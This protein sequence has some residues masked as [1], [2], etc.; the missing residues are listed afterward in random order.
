MD[1]VLIIPSNGPF[2][3]K[4]GHVISNMVDFVKKLSPID[5]HLASIYDTMMAKLANNSN[6]SSDLFE[7]Y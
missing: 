2:F 7:K 5:D 3:S 1:P 4:Y 6:L